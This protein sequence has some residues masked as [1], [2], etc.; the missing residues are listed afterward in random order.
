MQLYV[1][2]PDR[3]AVLDEKMLTAL[4]SLEGAGTTTLSWRSPLQQP[5]FATDHP[6]HEYR[7]GKVFDAVGRPDL[8]AKWAEYWPG[9]SQRWDGLAV[10]RDASGAVVGPVLVEAKSYLAEFRPTSGGTRAEGDR[11]ELIERRLRETRKWLEVAETSDVARR[12]LG[13]LYQ[14]ANR[15]ATLC[16]FRSFCDPPVDAWLLNL[17]FVNDTTHS[18]EKLATSQQQ[19]ENE[20]PGAERDLGLEGKHVPH[21]GRAY[22]EAGTYDELLA[23]TGG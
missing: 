9:R 2:A 20:L 7:D 13:P 6:F 22:A 1:N 5:L 19:W 12:W 16:F 21:S 23:A 8:R 10:A 17:Y 15:F 14:S 3:R 11:L 18:N 4:P